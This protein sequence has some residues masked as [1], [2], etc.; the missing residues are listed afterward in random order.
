MLPDKNK[1]KHE[2]DIINTHNIKTIL[3]KLEERHAKPTIVNLGWLLVSGH[4]FS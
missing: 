3:A 4:N 1:S 2:H